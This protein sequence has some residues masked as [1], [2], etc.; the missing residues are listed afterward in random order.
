MAIVARERYLRAAKRL[1]RHVAALRSANP[2][3]WRRV[4]E[5]RAAYSR[6]SAGWPSCCFLPGGALADLAQEFPAIAKRI[7][8][9]EGLAAWRPSQGMYIFDRVLADELSRTAA[10]EPIPGDVLLQ[11]PEWCIYIMAAEGSLATWGLHGFFAFLS[12]LET[13]REVALRFLLDMDDDRLLATLPVP[14]SPG[15]VQASVER[16]ATEAGR[17]LATAGKSK[18]CDEL[19]NIDL[20]Q[21]S[22]ALAPLVSLVLYICSANADIVDS[23]RRHSSPS[24]PASTK[25]R[26]GPRIFPPEE[27]VL[28]EVGFRVGAAI[29]RGRGQMEKA[30]L[31]RSEVR[32]HLR[33]AHWHSF[34]TGSRSEPSSR[35]LRIKWLHPILVGAHDADNLPI[36]RIVRPTRGADGSP[37]GQC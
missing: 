8:L 36:V 30:A 12:Y 35:T 19:S 25:T 10:D 29:R 31:E 23:T 27:V 28:L 22:R 14:L 11:M 6:G 32:P 20:G 5:L 16:A 24:R 18:E 13:K 3:I 9:F 26:K 15:S 17:A 37:D 7:S 1:L 4:D 34:W 21:F 2:N 33:R